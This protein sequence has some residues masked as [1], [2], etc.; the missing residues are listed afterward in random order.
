MTKYIP[1]ASMLPPSDVAFIIDASKPVLA[2]GRSMQAEASMEP[3]AHPRGQLLWAEKGVL[4]VT[5][6]EAVWVVPTTHAM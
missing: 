5:G 1:N 6:E 2:H 4:R 3:H